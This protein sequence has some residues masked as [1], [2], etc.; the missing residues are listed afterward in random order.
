MFSALPALQGVLLPVKMAANHRFC[1]GRYEE[2]HWEVSGTEKQLIESVLSTD[3]VKNWMKER[4]SV[5]EP[6][7]STQNTSTA[8]VVGYI[9]NTLHQEEIHLESL[10][11]G[12]QEFMDNYPLI[13][14][15]IAQKIAQLQSLRSTDPTHLEQ[16]R[17]LQAKDYASTV[18]YR[19]TL[20]SM[21]PLHTSRAIRPVSVQSDELDKRQREVIEK[22]KAGSDD[23]TLLKALNKERELSILR[24]GTKKPITV[25]S[26]GGDH[27]FWQRIQEWNTQNP[28]DRY[29]LIRIT[30][31]GYEEEAARE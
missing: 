9:A 19:G 5:D 15:S 10:S 20:N 12:L 14:Q 17:E 29:S 1:G 23:K 21:V 31:D 2:L 27:D 13:K 4:E 7:D 11:D 22:L 25:L 6:V 8:S 28:K 18:L 3:Q 16:I 30:P 24:I 26:Y